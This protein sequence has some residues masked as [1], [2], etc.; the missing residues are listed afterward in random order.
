[1]LVLFSLCLALSMA[2]ARG[3]NRVA[4]RP[5]ERLASAMRDITA[6]NDYGLRLADD[7]APEFAV[8][9]DNFHSMVAAVELP[10]HEL[11][12]SARQL[13]EARDNAEKANVAKSQ[14][15]ANMS[16]E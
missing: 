13:R 11:T 5:I 6:S 4:F 7:P 10:D 14:F 1:M 9:T 2:A 12:D 15:L 8:I 16:H 3:L